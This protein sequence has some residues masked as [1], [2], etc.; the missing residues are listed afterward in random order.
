MHKKWSVLR[1]H[2]KYGPLDACLTHVWLVPY[3]NRDVSSPYNVGERISYS[4]GN[5]MNSFHIIVV[6]TIIFTSETG[7]G[8]V[9]VFVVHVCREVLLFG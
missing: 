2:V 6:I 1:S 7:V 9:K 5:L 4:M 3:V 8:G